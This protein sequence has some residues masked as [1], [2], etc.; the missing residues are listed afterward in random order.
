MWSPELHFFLVRGEKIPFTAM[1]DVYFLTGLPFRGMPLLVEPVLPRDTPL[2]TIGTRYCSGPDF[3][4]GT[5]VSMSAID[6]LTHRCIAVMIVHV[7]GSLV[8]Q[9]IS[10]GQLLVLERVVVGCE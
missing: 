5:V 8:T 3:M 10:G 4:S 6:S 9:R 1:E 7:Y 2:A